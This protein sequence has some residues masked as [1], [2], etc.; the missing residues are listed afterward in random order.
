MSPFGEWWHEHRRSIVAAA[1]AVW[2]VAS[3]EAVFFLGVTPSEAPCII[4]GGPR[5][6][7]IGPADPVPTCSASFYTEWEASLT[8]A[9]RLLQ[10]PWVIVIPVVGAMVVIGGGALVAGTVAHRRRGT[11]AG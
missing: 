8:L 10:T 2:F 7:A 3:I 9:D 6:L 1:I 4:A 5:A 11:P